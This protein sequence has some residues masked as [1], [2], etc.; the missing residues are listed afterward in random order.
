MATSIVCGSIMIFMRGVVPDA[1]G[2]SIVHETNGDLYI[3]IETGIITGDYLGQIVAINTTRQFLDVYIDGERILSSRDY[4]YT[5]PIAARYGIR[6][7]QEMIGGEMRIVFST[8]DLRE[9]MLMGNSLSFQRLNEGFLSLDYSITAVCI[10]AGIAALIFAFAFGIRSTSRGG[11]VLFALMNFALALNI[12]FGDTLIGLGAL[13]PRSIYIASYTLHFIYMLPMLAF[14][15]VTLTGLWKKFAFVLFISTALYPVAVFVLDAARIM[16]VGLSERG[17]NYVLALNMTILTVMLASQLAAKNRFSIIARINFVFWTVWGLSAVVRLLVFDMSIRV[18]VEYRLVYGFTLISLTFY[19]IYIFA[20][21]FNELQK[22]EYAM[23]VKAETLMQNYEQLGAY[24]HEINLLKHEMRNHLSMLRIFLKDN[25]IEEAQ[26]YLE[27]YS[28]EVDG[29][30]EAAYHEN[31]IVNAVAHDVLHRGR[32]IAANVVLILKTSPLRISEPD[33]ISLLANITD[34]ALE[35]CAKIPE[36]R[37]RLI[38]LTITRREPYLAVVCENSNP[39]GIVTDESG[40]F[41]SSK[42]ETGHG[43]G[44]KAIE[45]IAAVYDG[46]AEVTFNENRFTITVALKDK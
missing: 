19:G 30:T 4:G 37:E 32:I 5:E 24:F 13:E 1:Y 36:G 18:N 2:W 45:R 14:L 3:R 6:V 28:D 33:L 41:R 9:N 7:T 25:R 35:A 46:M 8:P 23:S 44:L 10:A 34:N 12:I 26:N 15:M 16:P 22:R 43:F 11:I 17:Y 38:L 20:R 42:N 31:Y 39:G 27:K 40:K 29:I 21:N